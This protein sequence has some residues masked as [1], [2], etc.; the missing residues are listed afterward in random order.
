MFAAPFTRPVGTKE[1]KARRKAILNLPYGVISLYFLLSEENL[2]KFQLLGAGQSTDDWS[3]E[4]HD[5]WEDVPILD[6]ITSLI[7]RTH[8]FMPPDV[9]LAALEYT[10]K[11]TGE[12]YVPGWSPTLLRTEQSQL[13]SFENAPEMKFFTWAN[14]DLAVHRYHN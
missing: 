7:A 5:R 8:C 11:G 6:W 13:V 3:N 9:E 2:R 10:P 1:M 4:K 12:P 14:V